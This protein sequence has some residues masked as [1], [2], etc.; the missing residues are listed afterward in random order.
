ML[1][2]GRR[3]FPSSFRVGL[4]A[5]NMVADI[6]WM[7]ANLRADRRDPLLMTRPLPTVAGEFVHLL[8]G[9]ER[10]DTLTLDDPRPAAVEAADLFRRANLLATRYIR[11][12]LARVPGLRELYKRRLR[13]A[14]IRART[15]HFVCKGNICRSPYAERYL[16]QRLTSAL[17]VAS[18]GYFPVAG[19]PSPPI[20]VS[21]AAEFGVRLEDHRSHVL[22]EAA[23]RGADV[24][25]VFDSQNLETFSAAYPDLR[26]R[27]FPIGILGGKSSSMT[28]DD[29]YEG[30]ATKF[31]RCY[32]QLSLLLDEIVL[33]LCGGR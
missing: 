25:F 8:T 20:A 31:R 3:S 18:S 10:W 13:S 30:D 7:R 19:R 14:L 16:A 11:F 2:K 9:R 23:L 5:R 4:Y 24:I 22:D 17:V 32:S 29:P 6:G 15:L 1:V 33:V 21:V 27:V 28:I 26:S 12:N